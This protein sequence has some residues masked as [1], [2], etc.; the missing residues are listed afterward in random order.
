[1]ISYIV[2]GN[3]SLMTKKV[4]FACTLN[5]IGWLIFIELSFIVLSEGSIRCASKERSDVIFTT[6]S[7]TESVF[8]T[9]G[10]QETFSCFSFNGSTST[11]SGGL[12]SNSVDVQY[13]LV[14]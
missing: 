7:V 9:G 12:G 8:S 6:Y 3:K 10:L 1:M 11:S 13:E 2:N 5:V 4:L 14:E